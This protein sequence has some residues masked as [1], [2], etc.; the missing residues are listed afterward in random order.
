MVGFASF[1]F[2]LQQIPLLSPASAALLL[3]CVASLSAAVGAT[4]YIVL[5]FL[6]VS[7]VV[8]IEDLPTW[9]RSSAAGS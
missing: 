1:F 3:V 7:R 5:S 2:A 4:L 9:R 8:V 6:L